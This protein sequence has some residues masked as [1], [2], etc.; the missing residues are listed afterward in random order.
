MPVHAFVVRTSSDARW[1]LGNLLLLILVLPLLIGLFPQLVRVAI[2][3]LIFP[4]VLMIES[5]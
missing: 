4:G 3:M 1:R 5:S 2:G